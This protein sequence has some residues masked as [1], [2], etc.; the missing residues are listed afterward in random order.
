[1]KSARAPCP[2]GGLIMDWTDRRVRWY[3]VALLV[4]LGASSGLAF[5]VP[6]RWLTWELQRSLRPTPPPLVPLS[7]YGVS[8]AGSRTIELSRL[9]SEMTVESGEDGSRVV[10]T[11]DEVARRLAALDRWSTAV[12]YEHW[13]GV[14]GLYETGLLDIETCA[15]LIGARWPRAAKK[16]VDWPS[17]PTQTW[18][19]V[20]LNEEGR[21][22]GS[23]CVSALRPGWE[24]RETTED[25][26]WVQSPTAPGD[27]VLPAVSVFRRLPSGEVVRD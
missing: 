8:G 22:V 14:G 20:L 16:S 26:V 17:F 23:T 9:C 15:R 11:P 24:V 18:R 12:L 21:S 5:T 10:P 19:L 6:G 27:G 2:A 1:M 7:L 4:A 3:R 25:R 13:L